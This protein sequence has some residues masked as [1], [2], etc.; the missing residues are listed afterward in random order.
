[1]G[2]TDDMDAAI[3]CGSTMVRIGTA[4]FRCV[5]ILYPDHSVSLTFRYLSALSQTG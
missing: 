5:T 4:I 2:M 3:T 1:M